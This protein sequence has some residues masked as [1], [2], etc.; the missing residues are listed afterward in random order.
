MLIG[1][2]AGILSV[3]QDINHEKL[4]VRLANTIFIARQIPP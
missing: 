1:M 4:M 3:S 2:I